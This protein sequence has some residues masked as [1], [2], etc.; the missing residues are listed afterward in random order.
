MQGTMLTNEQM[1]FLQQEKQ[2]LNE[3]KRILSD[4]NLPEDAQKALD[5]AILQLDELFLIVVVGEYNSG[6]SAL[7]NAL[8]GDHVLEEGVT[9]TTA[10]VTLVRWGE[11][12]S[13]Q[14]V[15]EDF[16]IVTYPLE[17]LKDLNLIDSPGTNAIIR[18]HELLT[19]EYVPRSDLVLFTT[20]ADRPL[21]ES[22][23]Q[24]LE[25][26]LAW[27]KKIALVINKV[28]ILEGRA[29]VDEVR[30][31]VAQHTAGIL[32]YTP[33]L[34]VLSAKLAEKANQTSDPEEKERLRK[35]SGITDL[36]RYITETLDDRARLEL[37]FSNPIGVA[38]N[39]LSQ[40]EDL[41]RA[42]SEELNADLKLVSELEEMLAIYRKELTAE[43]KPRLAEV[44]NVLQ[45]FEQRGEEFFNTNLR[46]TNIGNLAKSDKIKA[47]FEEEVLAGL[48]SEI[49]AKVHGMIDWMVDK[50]L[51]AW[52]QVMAALERRQ[53]VARK[54]TEAG[55]MSPQAARRT[56]LMASVGETIKTI[57]NSYNHKKEAEELSVLVEGAVAQTA[58]FEVGAV[59]LGALVA[60][61]L[62][63]AAMDVTGIVAASALAILGFFV[64]PY[65][66]KQAIERFKEKMNDL[67]SNLMHTLELTFGREADL[68]LSRLEAKIAPYTQGVRADQEKIT[69]DAQT[70]VELKQT[71]EEL[72][73]QMHTVL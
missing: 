45:N 10:R 3:A 66:R 52:Y 44:D 72:R 16:A 4:F 68:A 26:I 38:A 25:K 53:F 27:G 37:K 1:L 55:P 70:L 17:L 18:R 67:R 28:D 23:R 9:P 29:A 6:K 59:G 34:F 43:I 69:R 24:F 61:T 8:L 41:N 7:I 2:Q 42:Q 50:D 39:L 71:L 51:H 65:K 60:S 11:A 63:S 5:E 21:T 54:Q 15:N 32:G 49:D 12:L 47:K 40:A 57:V 64:I 62:F 35:D 30:A 22:E 14:I 56:D 46:I 13:E 33:E 48:S 19:T 73:D 20:S 58:L 36:E 31:F